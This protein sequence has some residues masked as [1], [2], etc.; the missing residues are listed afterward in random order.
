MPSNFAAAVW[1]RPLALMIAAIFAV[2]SARARASSGE[3][4]S[5]SAKTSPLLLVTSAL[6]FIGELLLPLCLGDDPLSVKFLGQ[7][8]SALPCIAVEIIDHLQDAGATKPLQ[9]LRVRMLSTLLRQ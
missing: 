3:E 5:R 1:V 4:T 7:L 8:Q 6:L 9:R 2:S